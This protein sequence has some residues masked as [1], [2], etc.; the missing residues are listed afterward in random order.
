MIC[1]C[2]GEVGSHSPWRQRRCG[3]FSASRDY[4]L[5]ECGHFH[6][7]QRRKLL[8]FFQELVEV[9]LEPCCRVE[10]ALSNTHRCRHLPFTILPLALSLTLIGWRVLLLLLGNT[11]S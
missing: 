6:L 4:L 1:L 5:R 8:L 3:S 2:L 9:G 11:R 10:L 7:H